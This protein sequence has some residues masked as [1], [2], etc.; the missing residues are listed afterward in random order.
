MLLFTPAIPFL[1]HN[2]CCASQKQN[3]KNFFLS[4]LTPRDTKQ[5]QSVDKVKKK[6]AFLYNFKN[7]VL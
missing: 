7:T 5:Y 6:M 2:L 4:Y 1:Q 3:E